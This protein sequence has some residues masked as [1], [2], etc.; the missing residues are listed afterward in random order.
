MEAIKDHWLG[1]FKYIRTCRGGSF[2]V[3]QTHSSSVLGLS[4][5]WFGQKGSK[6]V[7]NVMVTSKQRYEEVATKEGGRK[8]NA[9][10]KDY[11]RHF[12]RY[13]LSTQL[14]LSD[15]SWL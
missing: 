14:S 7:L 4:R 8:R 12:I 5:R 9:V 10:C 2:T 1:S 3:L 15:L 11:S 13:I 6:S